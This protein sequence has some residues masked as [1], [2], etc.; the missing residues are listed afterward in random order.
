[1]IRRFQGLHQTDPSAAGEFP[2]G[3]FQVRV[4]QA[5]YRWHAQKP[6][7]LLC[8]TVVEPKTFSGRTVTSRLY[9]SPKA[10]WKLTWFLRDFGYDVDLLGRDEVDDKSLVGLSGVVKISNVVVNGRSLIN[11]DGFAPAA[12]WEELSTTSSAKI[13]DPEVA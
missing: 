1:M 12:Q 7:Y 10:L 2:D 8:F 13:R 4:H 5:Q 9:C 6:Y 11:L 3:L